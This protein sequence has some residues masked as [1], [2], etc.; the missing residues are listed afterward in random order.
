[1]F[2]AFVNRTLAYNYKNHVGLM[3]FSTRP[4]I[5]QHITDVLEDFRCSVRDIQCGGFTALWDTLA[6]ANEE[7]LEYGQ[8][9]PEAKKRIICLSDGDDTKSLQS[10]WEVTSAIQVIHCSKAV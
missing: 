6:L 4:H 2:E 5:R 10:A 8:R 1:M 3:T 9:F 7:L